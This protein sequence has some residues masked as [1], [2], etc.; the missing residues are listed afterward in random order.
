MRSNLLCHKADQ[1]LPVIGIGR[2]GCNASLGNFGGQDR[3]SV[4]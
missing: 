3:K 1:W 2:M 4:S